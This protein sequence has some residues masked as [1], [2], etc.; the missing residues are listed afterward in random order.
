MGLLV[1]ESIEAGAF[2]GEEKS[3][4]TLVLQLMH[5]T[6]QEGPKIFLQWVSRWTSQ[7]T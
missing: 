4:S 6:R 2:A 3:T 7:D 5:C 1:S